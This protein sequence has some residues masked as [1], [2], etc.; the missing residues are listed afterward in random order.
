MNI[1]Y[2]GYLERCSEYVKVISS[3]FLDIPLQGCQAKQILNSRLTEPL[4]LFFKSK[5][6]HEFKI[7]FYN[8]DTS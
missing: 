4:Y 2:L 8:S 7:T 1:T 3:H 5:N 6:L